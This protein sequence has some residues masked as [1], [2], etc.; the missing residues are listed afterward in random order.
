MYVIG[1]DASRAH[2]P[3]EAPS[4]KE[5]LAVC[6]HCEHWRGV[7]LRGHTL[8]VAINCPMGRFRCAPLVSLLIP[9]RRPDNRMLNDTIAS[10]LSR[11]DHPERV[12]ILVRLDEDQQN[13]RDG[14]AAKVLVG[15]RFR[16][17]RDL[18]VFYNELAAASTGDWLWMMNDDAHM[19]TTGWDT[20]LAR[21]VHRNQ[22]GVTE[23]WP[24]TRVRG[25]EIHYWSN[26]FPVVSRGFYRVLGHF[27]Q[28]PLNDCY[29]RLLALAGGFEQ[30]CAVVVNH[31]YLNEANGKQARDDHYS[32]EMQRLVDEDR[33]RFQAAGI[34]MRPIDMRNN[35]LAV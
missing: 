8:H 32:A 22:A 24:K 27:S 20:A 1:N 4:F 23:L 34:P 2:I 31:Q 18:H 25:G 6:R 35:R 21:I 13:R 5:R 11:A 15:P 17:Y 30:E 33:A 19:E 12:E 14:I 28:S 29:V 9:S 10:F 3:V 26:D 16:G 7:C